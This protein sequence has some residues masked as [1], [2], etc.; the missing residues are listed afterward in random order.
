MQAQ[1]RNFSYPIPPE[2]KALDF[3]VPERMMTVAEQVTSTLQA[4]K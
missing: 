4:I 1:Q 2:V 3:N